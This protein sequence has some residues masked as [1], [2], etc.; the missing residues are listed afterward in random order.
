[1]S[2]P[3]YEYRVV[4]RTGDK[5]SG[6]V[7]HWNLTTAEMER[8]QLSLAHRPM[9]PHTIERRPVGEWEPLP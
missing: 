8:V 1:M 3:K 4:D 7:L 9:N 5:A 6:S 2:A